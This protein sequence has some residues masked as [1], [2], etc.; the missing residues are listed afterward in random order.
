MAVVFERPKSLLDVPT[1]FCPGCG[2]GIVHRLVC[3][4]LD[5]MDIEGD[6]IGVVP[7]GCSVM[8]YDYFGCDVIEAP[9]GRAPADHRPCPRSRSGPGSRS[10]RR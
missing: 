8:S 1:H 7:V 9:H 6:T 2:H 4:V 5:E 3:E 10:G